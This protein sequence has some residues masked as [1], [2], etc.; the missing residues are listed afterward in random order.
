MFSDG[1]IKVNNLNGD[2]SLKGEN[3][4]L[5]NDSIEIIAKS[6]DGNFNDITDKKEITFLEVLMK[7]YL[8]LKIMRPKCIKKL[9]SIMIHQLLN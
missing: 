9:I 5:I 1:F 2:F 4:R 6:I 3:S 8:M 7:Q